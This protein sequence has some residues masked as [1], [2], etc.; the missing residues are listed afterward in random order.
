[1]DGEWTT[2]QRRRRQDNK[3]RKD[4]DDWRS[5]QG[6]RQENKGLNEDYNKVMKCKTV[7]FFFTRFPDSWNEKNLWELFKKYGTVADLYLA[8]RRTKL[9]TRFGFVRYVNVGDTMDFK[10]K[11]GGISISNVKILINIA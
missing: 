9:G 5:Q 4:N 6:R 7:T 10:K 1:M 3:D 2:V 8:Y 11:L